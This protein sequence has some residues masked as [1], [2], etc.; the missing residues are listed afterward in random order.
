[1]AAAVLG[2]G[3]KIAAA[4][5]VVVALVAYLPARGKDIVV[6]QADGD[7]SAGSQW[8]ALWGASLLRN[9]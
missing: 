2:L 8:R 5:F 4:A 7:A 3:V 9:L 6:Y 1:M